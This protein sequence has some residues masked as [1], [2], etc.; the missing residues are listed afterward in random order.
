MV[1]KF[2]DYL[3]V[4]IMLDKC[5]RATIAITATFLIT[6]VQAADTIKIGLV[7]P[8]TGALATSGK[9]IVAAAR[10]YS[11]RCFQAAALSAAGR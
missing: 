8:M 2:G 10:L 3:G 6:T 5:I 4:S 11:K 1:A 9:Q 7:M